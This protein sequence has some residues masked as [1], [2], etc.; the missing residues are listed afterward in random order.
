MFLFLEFNILH[1][2]YFFCVDQLE[3][4]AIICQKFYIIILLEFISLHISLQR[5][6]SRYCCMAARRG[7]LPRH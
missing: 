2:F 7:Y 6:A 3:K 5:H 1:S 4:H